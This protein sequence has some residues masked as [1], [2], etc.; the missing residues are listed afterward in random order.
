MALPKFL[1]TCLWSYDISKMDP[2]DS[3][4]KELIIQ[5]VLNHGGSEALKW[6]FK[7][8]KREDIVKVVKSPRR[9]MWLPRALNYW[10]KVLEVKVP[11]VIYEAALFSLHPRF[12][13]MDKYFKYMEKHKKD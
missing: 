2:H 3:S 8:Y 12:D 13:V 6:F 4:D 10:T 9:G 1:Q 11:K 5:Q 7:T